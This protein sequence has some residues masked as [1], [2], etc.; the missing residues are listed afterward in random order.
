M[1]AAK[2]FAAA[3]FYSVANDFA[4]AVFA[5]RRDDC[6][7]AFEAVEDVGLTVFRKFER[8][9]VIVSAQFAFGHKRFYLT[10]WFRC[11]SAF[12]ALF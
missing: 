1:R 3:S 10:S 9:V 2:D 4:A 5:F 7:R 8:L 11:Q 12:C 6:D